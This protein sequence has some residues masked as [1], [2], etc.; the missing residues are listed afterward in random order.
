MKT[1]KTID[2]NKKATAKKV[3]TKV[4]KKTKK[5]VAK[6]IVKKAKKIVAK[7]VTDSTVMT[8]RNIEKKTRV[9]MLT[10]AATEDITIGKLLTKMTKAYAA[11]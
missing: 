2:G 7:N 3:L 5:K 9:K 1:V 4:A 11:K 6:K 8:I 10:L